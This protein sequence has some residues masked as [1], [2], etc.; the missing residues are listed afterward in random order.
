M[1]NTLLPIILIAIILVFQSCETSTQV[2]ETQEIIAPH[3]IQYN[4]SSAIKGAYVEENHS[5]NYEVKKEN[6]AYHL[7]TDIDG[8]ILEAIVSY[9]DYSIE[10]N[11]N[12]NTLSPTQMLMLNTAAVKL[13]EAIYGNQEADLQNNCTDGSHTGSREDERPSQFSFTEVENTLVQVLDYWSQA[14]EGYVYETYRV[15]FEQE[16]PNERRGNDG[17]SC[18]KRGRTYTL[19][20]DGSAGNTNV[21][22]KAGYNGGGSYGCMGRCGVGCGRSW[23]PSSWTLDCF[24]HD[25]CSLRYGASGGSSDRNCGDEFN[26]AADDWVF[27]VIRGCFG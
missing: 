1:K 23:I 3:L 15:V 21:S 22:R 18:V 16:A 19:Q 13:G 10:F 25:E 12:E 17:V 24:E 27:G 4:Y 9:E 26:E 11:G 2:V 7:R 8:K 20:Y 14:P 5:L 6:E